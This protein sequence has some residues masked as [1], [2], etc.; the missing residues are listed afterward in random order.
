MDQQ[1]VNGVIDKKQRSM[2]NPRLKNLLQLL[3]NQNSREDHLLQN[4]DEIPISRSKKERVAQQLKTKHDEW[5]FD[6]KS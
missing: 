1:A 3:R 2:D 5:I 6:N 4:G